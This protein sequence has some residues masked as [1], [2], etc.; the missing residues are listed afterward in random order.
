LA[1]AN[2]DSDK[3][4]ASLSRSDLVDLVH[5]PAQRAGA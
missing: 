1:D 2:V 4:L 5:C 3:P